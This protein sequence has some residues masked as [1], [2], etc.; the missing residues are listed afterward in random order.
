MTSATLTN[1]DAR[2]RLTGL[3]TQYLLTDLGQ[4]EGCFDELS[5]IEFAESSFESIPIAARDHIC[6][7]PRCASQYSAFRGANVV[8]EL[9]AR[10]SVSL[11][12]GELNEQSKSSAGNVQV[13]GFVSLEQQV[14]EECSEEEWVASPV[15]IRVNIAIDVEADFFG[16]TL[17]DLP[18][19]IAA[20]SLRLP[21]GHLSLERVEGHDLSEVML[22]GP[23]WHSP[24]AGDVKL[25]DVIDALIAGGASVVFD[26]ADKATSSNNHADAI[27]DLLQ[28][29]GAIERDFDYVL[30][31]GLHADTH[32]NL[33]TI[34]RSEE[35]L[36]QIAAAFDLLFFD[37]EF[38]T[39]VTNGWAMA[40]IA[41]RLA[42]MR[43]TRWTKRPIYDVMSE[44][45]DKPVLTSDI[46]LGKSLILIDVCVTGSLVEKL[47]GIVR[48]AGAQVVGIGCVVRA[49]WQ[50]MTVDPA[51][52]TLT[53]VQMDI[54]DPMREECSRCKQLSRRVFNPFSHSMTE[55]APKG[56]S[57]SEFARTC[58]G[59]RILA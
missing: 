32:V 38:D 4:T 8:L 56:R 49:A 22:I 14:F 40:T 2:Q 44:G 51:L 18:P 33:G 20:V 50:D 37:V 42:L 55:K 45:Y 7:C 25:S 12:I 23:E 13:L 39:I 59:P 19:E 6:H 48:Q 26:M 53:C 30:P 52:R 35:S 46:G 31:S 9:P 57:P 17:L 1:R 24:R 15:R 11:A 47:V 58:R 5:L 43:S 28:S 10:W 16:L 27:L 34:C 3:A 29:S 41:R 54:V 21:T 36:S